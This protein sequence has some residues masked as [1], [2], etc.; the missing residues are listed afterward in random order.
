[1][2]KLAPSPLVGKG[3]AAH[4]TDYPHKTLT[5]RNAS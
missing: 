5:N 4:H 1:M 3:W 2:T